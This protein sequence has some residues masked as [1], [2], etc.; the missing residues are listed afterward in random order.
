MFY[1]FS[2]SKPFTYNI[3]TYSVHYVVI[4][5]YSVIKA[6]RVISLIALLA[7]NLNKI[8]A[9]FKIADVTVWNCLN[10]SKHSILCETLVSE[11]SARFGLA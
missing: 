7:M 8:L 4:F 6:S 10:I 3:K 9:N 5:E 11:T 1:I 2:G